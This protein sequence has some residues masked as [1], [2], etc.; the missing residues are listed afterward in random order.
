MKDDNIEHCGCPYCKA[1]VEVDVAWAKKNGKVFC[2][3]CCKSFDLR[4]EEDDEEEIPEEE[5]IKKEEFNF[6]YW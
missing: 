4:I 3:G 6:D 2:N 1:E 5:E